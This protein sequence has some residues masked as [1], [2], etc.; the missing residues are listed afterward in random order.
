MVGA[1]TN[2]RSRST[3]ARS[4]WE[5]AHTLAGDAGLGPRRAPARNVAVPQPCISRRRRTTGR[6]HEGCV[7]AVLTTGTNLLMIGAAIELPGS[8]NAFRC[9]A[10]TCH[11]ALH[12]RPFDADLRRVRGAPPAGR[13]HAC[14]GCAFDPAVTGGAAVQPGHAGRFPRCR[15]HWLPPPARARRPAPPQAGC[16]VTTPTGASRRFAPT[17]IT[18]RPTNSTPAWTRC[19]SSRA[20]IGARSCAPRR[21]GGAATA[22]SSPT[23]C[24]PEG[25]A[26]SA[27][28]RRDRANPFASRRARSRSPVRRSPKR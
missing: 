12:H 27:P 21:C 8:A 19:V 11:E 3:P 24:W 5:T 4:S 16:A 2:S 9:R 17:P 20:A 14:R 6:W 13:D 23:I 25:Y 18:R 10:R 28:P 1:A 15:R 26:L 7:L 22:G